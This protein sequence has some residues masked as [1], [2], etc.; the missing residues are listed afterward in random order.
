M[1]SPP[2]RPSRSTPS[3]PP[4]G[5]QPELASGELL[6]R[7][8][9]RS[10]APLRWGTLVVVSVPEPEYL[11]EVVLGALRR[12]EKE[13][14]A[15]AER[16]S[17]AIYVGKLVETPEFQAQV[18]AAEAAAGAGFPGARPADE[19]LAELRAFSERLGPRS[20]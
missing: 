3:D 8:P 1:P 18:E 10:P 19:V 11:S 15:A 2:E 16:I 4:A 5:L 7:R 6:V 12:V 17:L 14:H 13:I 9:G 20:A